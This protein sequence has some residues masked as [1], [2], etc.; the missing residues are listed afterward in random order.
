MF[1]VVCVASVFQ[2]S[3]S[4]TLS[5][6]PK[7]SGALYSQS[8]KFFFNIFHQWHLCMWLYEFHFY[9]PFSFSL[10]IPCIILIG[11]ELGISDKE[12]MLDGSLLHVNSK[13]G[14]KSVSH[15][16]VPLKSFMFR[17]KEF[18]IKR[19]NSRVLQSSI[20]FVFLSIFHRLF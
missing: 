10:L 3:I 16:K 17:T 2:R 8:L 1:R 12:R 15:R 9:L 4:Y 6:Q 7:H 5:C 20:F 13:G 11:M 19:N 14:Y 18:L